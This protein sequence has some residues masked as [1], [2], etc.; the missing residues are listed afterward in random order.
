[1]S[2]ARSLP[3]SFASVV[4]PWRA[5][6]CAL[7]LGACLALM[8]RPAAAE[9]TIAVGSSPGSLP[10]F[11][12][13]SEGFFAA[14]GVQV[15]LTNCAFGKLCLRELLDGKAQ[16]C[17][18][19]D[20]PIVLASHSNEK[21]SV[22]ATLSTNR[23]DTKIVSLRSR[24]IRG[25]TDLVGRK[26]GTH[27]GTTA[28]YSLDMLLLIEGVDPS[29]TTLVELKPGEAG[30]RLADGT[31]DAV[32]LFEPQAFN[33]ARALGGDGQ[34]LDTQRI[35]TQTWNLVSAVGARG[36]S[37]A[38]LGA[39]L[40]ALDRASALIVRD[41]AR[42]KAVLRERLQFDAALVEQSWPSL[43]YELGLSQSLLA[44]LEGQA[45]WARRL[46]LVHS[47]TPNFLGIVDT[48]PLR[49]VRPAAVSI[50]Q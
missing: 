48:A 38:E 16:L 1:M 20:L 21:F 13:Q 36:P 28:H 7:L 2:V 45:H 3:C 17:T 49:R 14:E 33:A 29:R 39:V 11:L 40:R 18:V 30:A 31:V 12:A 22:V 6:A 37:A 10:I 26:V 46:G 44:T 47:A 50:A 42:A 24:G 35:Y 19:A 23:N 27:S 25:V 5:A 15:R 8:G 9:V 43:N 41:P 34:V 4:A 32:A